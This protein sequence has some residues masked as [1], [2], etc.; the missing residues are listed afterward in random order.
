MINYIYLYIVKYTYGRE[1]HSQY[2]ES[3]AGYEQMM[4]V[5]DIDPYN[6][7]GDPNSGLIN[8]VQDYQIQEI[9]TADHLI[10]G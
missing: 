1:S 5:Y 8:M 2:D 4:Y 10:M 3:L 9:G 7:P 6:T